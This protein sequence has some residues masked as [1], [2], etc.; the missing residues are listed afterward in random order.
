MDFLVPIGAP[1]NFCFGMCLC[2]LLSDDVFLSDDVI[3]DIFNLAVDVGYGPNTLCK[4]KTDG[5]IPLCMTI[6]LQRALENLLP[7][8]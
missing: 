8:V 6:S 4:T 3:R 7:G 5:M 1:M 2:L